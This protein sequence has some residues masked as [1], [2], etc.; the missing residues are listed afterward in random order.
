M[1]IAHKALAEKN[2][3][4]AAKHLKS[5]AEIGRAEA[6]FTLGLLHYQGNTGKVDKISAV[7]WL[8]LASEYDHPNALAYTQQV[9]SELSPEMQKK[10]QA[11]MTELANK[12]GKS[13]VKNN[14][15]PRFTSQPIKA[16]R[17]N[18]RAKLL[19]RGPLE[20]KRGSARARNEMA[21]NSAIRNAQFGG[22]STLSTS[23]VNDDSGMVIVKY[24]VS[25]EG[26]PVYPEVL[27]S[28]PKGRFDKP[29]LDA[30]IKSKLRPAQINK[31][32]AF[33]LGLVSTVRFGFIDRADFKNDYPNQYKTFK[34]LQRE[35]DQDINSKYLYAG[36][37]NAYQQLLP[38]KDAISYLSVITELAESGHVLAQLD[39]GQYL[40]FQQNEY[41]EGVDWIQK[42]ANFGYDKAEFRLGELLMDPPTPLLQKDIKKAEFWLTRI[43]DNLPEAQLKLTSLWL[44]NGATE[45]QFNKAKVWLENIIEDTDALPNV[46]YLLAQ[47]ELKLNQEKC[48]KQNLEQAIT[49]G[50]DLNWNTKTWQ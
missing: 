28:W 32:D 49:I 35:S 5:S 14:I 21:I 6:Q 8:F 44:E 11:Y 25:K 10:A 2:Y 38:K 40:I 29:T 3:A 23:L 50:D 26:N 1:S 4:E 19:V 9:Y 18:R 27:F 31:Q 30:V 20:Y 16:Q 34:R 22:L 7:G 45:A 39:L 47:T 13:A 43:A 17:F 36:F 41:K 48:F 24:D 12:Y 37:L 15:Y 46:Y 42:A 33:Q